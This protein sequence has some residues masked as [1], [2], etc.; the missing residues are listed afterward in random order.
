MAVEAREHVTGL[1]ALLSTASLALVFAAAGG[2]IPAD[3]FPRP[4]PSVVHAIPHVNAAISGAAIVLIAVGW[5]AIRRG[6]V[7]RHRAAMLAAAVL[8]ALFLALYLY[9]VVLEGPATFP[10]PDAIYRLVYVPVLAVHVTLAVVCVPLLYYVL[11]IGV[12]HPVG[13]IPR[14]RHPRVGRIAA[15]LWLVSFVLGDA[16]FL[17]LYVL[18]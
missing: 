7:D 4:H 10:G 15:A 14:T 11:L 16:V 8:F 1:A 12:T 13:A 5:R 6:R 18:Y 2:I 3:A 9:K 17:L